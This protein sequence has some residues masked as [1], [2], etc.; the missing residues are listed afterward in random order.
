MLQR[1]DVH[2]HTQSCS[3]II[4]S[5]PPF[6][7]AL[8]IF[9]TIYL[10]FVLLLLFFSTII[11]FN[12]FC[13]VSVKAIGFGRLEKTTDYFLE[14]LQTRGITSCS[15]IYRKFLPEANLRYTTIQ[16][17]RRFD[18][19]LQNYTEIRARATF[20]IFVLFLEANLRY[21]T[22]MLFFKL[23]MSIINV[24]YKCHI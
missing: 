7:K 23:K 16:I 19:E 2:R 14:L 20:I 12:G 21:T 13:R 9:S 8:F 22:I 10:I 5:R 3:N 17:L 1:V 24:K 6:A 4:V 18:V 11:C 15:N